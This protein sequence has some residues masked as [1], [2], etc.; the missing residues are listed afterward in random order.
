MDGHIILIIKHCT[1]RHLLLLGWKHKGIKGILLN[2]T[3]KAMQ[4]QSKE[5]L[6][7]GSNNT[8]YGRRGSDF[9]GVILNAK[10]HTRNVTSVIQSS[11]N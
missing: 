1:A 5:D 3:G 10:G 11:N 8:H 7:L 6:S 9:H 4:F 2:R